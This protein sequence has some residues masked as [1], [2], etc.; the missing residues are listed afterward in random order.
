M[1]ASTVY[2]R[3][4]CILSRLSMWKITSS[5]AASLY[6]STFLMIFKAITWSLNEKINFRNTLS[7]EKSV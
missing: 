6:L 3:E 1:N 7:F 5:L 4:T 2:Y